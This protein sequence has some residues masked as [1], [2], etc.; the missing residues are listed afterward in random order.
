MDRRTIQRIFGF[1]A[2][3]NGIFP[4]VIQTAE[5]LQFTV[6]AAHAGE[7]LPVVAG[8]QKLEVLHTRFDD[9]L[10]MRVDLHSVCNRSHAGS[11]KAL[12]TFYFHNAHAA[13]TDLIDLLQEAE[14][15]DMNVYHA[16]SFQHRNACRNLIFFIVDFNVYNISHCSLPPFLKRFPLHSACRLSCRIRSVCR[17]PGE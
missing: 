11:D 7:A 2:V 3:I 1:F 15:R 10:C 13:C 16:G 4:D 9:P 17:L 5:G 14:S 12:C 8:Q 6:S